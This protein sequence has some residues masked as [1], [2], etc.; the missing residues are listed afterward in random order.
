[1]GVGGGGGHVAGA[2]EH[3]SGVEVGASEG[4]GPVERRGEGER[5]FQV[6]DGVLR[7]AGV[8]G[9]DGQ[10]LQAHED[11]EAVAVGL[12]G[13]QGGLVGRVGFFAV[14]FEGG[15]ES[16]GAFTGVAQPG[17]EPDGPS[18]FQG[19]A[20]EESASFVVVAVD[21]FDPGR[22]HRTGVGGGQSGE[23]AQDHQGQ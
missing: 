21:V 2:S 4:D 12:G 15:G 1:M 17:P 5:A 10:T 18:V 16:Q 6:G 20:G 11:G 14:G 22:F 13:A 3:A 23:G 7:T 19:G 9:H 8:H